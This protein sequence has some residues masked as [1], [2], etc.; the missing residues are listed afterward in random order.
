MYTIMYIHVYVFLTIIQ[1]KP[2]TYNADN[3]NNGCCPNWTNLIFHVH[4]SC[5]QKKSNQTHFKVK[6]C[7]P[8]VKVIP[9]TCQGQTQFSR[10]NYVIFRFKLNRQIHTVLQKNTYTCSFQE[11]T[12]RSEKQLII[13]HT[14]WKMNL[15]GQRVNNRT[16]KNRLF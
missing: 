4:V 14:R 13:D 9:K 10:S 15:H 12:H 7:I 16:S 11:N 3:E 5:F 2:Q 1:V 6:Q 8:V